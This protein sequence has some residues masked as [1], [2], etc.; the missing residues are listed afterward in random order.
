MNVS[1]MYA[2]VGS[3]YIQ[4]GESSQMISFHDPRY[5]LVFI[6]LFDFKFVK[7]SN[8]WNIVFFVIVTGDSNCQIVK[9]YKFVNLYYWLAKI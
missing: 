1:H 7:K 2:L 3:V 6:D 4:M 5:S 9:F 8:Y